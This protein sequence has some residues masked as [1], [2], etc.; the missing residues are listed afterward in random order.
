MRQGKKEADEV[1]ENNNSVKESIKRP[2]KKQKLAVKKKIEESCAK[3]KAKVNEIEKQ[4]AEKK[5][6]SIQCKRKRY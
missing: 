5:K 3:K 2:Q 6:R 1:R 4:E